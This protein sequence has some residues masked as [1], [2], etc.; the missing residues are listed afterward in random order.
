VDLVLPHIGLIARFLLGLDVLA[1]I[2][3]L[4]G[5]YREARSGGMVAQNGTAIT[6][7]GKDRIAKSRLQV[8]ANTGGDFGTPQIRVRRRLVG[9]LYSHRPTTQVSQKRYDRRL[10]RRWR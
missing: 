9:G 2:T 1:L 3:L 7:T 6:P 4:G 10:A 8:C 5:A